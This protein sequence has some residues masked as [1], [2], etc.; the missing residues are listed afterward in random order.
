M[1][2]KLSI[3]LITINFLLLIWQSI[4]NIS[5]STQGDKLSQYVNQLDSVTSQ[6][7]ILM[8]LINQNSS[9]PQISEKATKLGFVSATITRLGLK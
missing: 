8:A 1:I 9:L 3:T 5:L 6:N 7:D 2:K 4:L